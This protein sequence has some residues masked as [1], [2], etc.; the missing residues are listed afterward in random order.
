ML[1]ALGTKNTLLLL[2]RVLC[3]SDRQDQVARTGVEHEATW[4]Q[5]PWSFEKEQLGEKNDNL[6]PF[7]PPLSQCLLSPF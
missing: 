7:L 2:P 6:F 1:D 4:N 3:M 5:W